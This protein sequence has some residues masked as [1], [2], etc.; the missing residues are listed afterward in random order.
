MTSQLIYQVAEFYAGVNIFDSKDTSKPTLWEATQ[1]YNPWKMILK[2]WK[3]EVDS[4]LSMHCYHPLLYN[5]SRKQ[6]TVLDLECSFG[7]WMRENKSS[8]ITYKKLVS[9]PDSFI[10]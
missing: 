2:F 1:S 8:T 3:S 4:F 9:Y 7:H 5:H 10:L 6:P